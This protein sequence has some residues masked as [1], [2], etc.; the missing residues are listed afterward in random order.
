M[1]MSL[2]LPTTLPALESAPRS[3]DIPAGDA[4]AALKRF[5]AQAHEQ[6]L[7]STDD[8]SGLSTQ[9]IVG[10]FVPLAALHRML[11]NTPL[12]ARQDASTQ[13]ISITLSRPSR[14]P[15]AEP[16]PPAAAPLFPSPS[17]TPKP[18]STLKT[19]R[20]LT[21]FA[22]WLAA[23]SVISAQP[24]GSPGTISGRVDNLSTGRYLQGVEIRLDD[25][26]T[27]AVT[28]NQGRYSLYSVTGGDHTLEFSYVGLTTQKQAVTVPSGAN[29]IVDVSL[30]SNAYKLDK[31]VVV[32]ERE[33]RAAAISRQR[34]DP[35]IKGVIATDEYQNVSSGN[36]G[37]LLK[38]VPGVAIDYAGQDARS[39][40][41]RGIASNL[42]SVTVDSMRFASAASGGRG[43]SFDLDQVTLQNYS[44][45]EV[46]K[47]PTPDME[48]SSIGGNVNLVTKS[49]FEQKRRIVTAALNFNVTNYNLDGLDSKTRSINGG[50]TAEKIR[51]GGNLYFS[52]TFNVFGGR[53]NLGVVFTF[54]DFDT[55]IQA[56]RIN[57]DL[58][59]NTQQPNAD[60]GALNYTRISSWYLNDSPAQ[61][62]R[63]GVSLNLDYRLTA[64][65][66]L[67]LYTQ[68]NSSLIANRNRQFRLNANTYT[69]DSDLA[70]TTAV[71]A[72]NNQAIVNVDFN[73]KV[74]ASYGVNPG[75]KQMF[76]PLT[77]T[78]DVFVNQSANKYRDIPTYYSGITATLPN[79]GFTLNGRPDA[80]AP[81]VVQTAGPDLFNL[82]NY[83]TMQLNS[84]QRSGMDKF[85]GWKVDAKREFSGAIPFFLKTG[86]QSYDEYRYIDN[87]RRRWNYSGPA[88]NFGQLLDSTT[89]LGT[90]VTR[91]NLPQPPL[92][93]PQAVTAFAKANPQLFPEDKV[94]AIQSEAGR[95]YQHE[96]VTGAYFMGSFKFGQLTLLTGGRMEWT[97]DDGSGQRINRAAG[98]GIP[99]PIAQNL[100]VYAGRTRASNSYNNKFGN[101]QLKYEITRDLLVRVSGH[102]AIGRPDL[103]NILPSQNVD[104]PNRTVSINNVAIRP[105]VAGNID[106]SVE[107]YAP[108]A[109]TLTAGV[110][111]KN[112][113]DFITGLSTVIPAG[114]DNGF[115]GNYA[116]YTLNSQYNIG[117]A[118]FRGL[119]L[120][121]SQPFIGLPG[122]LSGFGG[123]AN[124]TWLRTEQDNPQVKGENFQNFVTRTVNVGLS[125]TRGR[126]LI[127]A[128]WNHRGTYWAYTSGGLNAYQAA[129]N[130]IDIAVRYP[131]Y[132]NIDFTFDAK[133][134]FNERTSFYALVP[135]RY[136]RQDPFGV[137]YNFGIRATF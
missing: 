47:A 25:G 91:W 115:Q 78:Y 101:V 117:F 79:I 72:A 135:G 55:I 128:K 60:I 75:A 43:R 88:G 19:S 51:P 73:D 57:K 35:G 30:D 95:S 27:E 6:L 102:Q 7:Y 114:P 36:I 71:Q 124:A 130:T 23:T 56:Y 8:V 111:R 76:G 49:A 69:A 86:A 14:A 121:A 80:S 116:G 21:F 66:T 98:I 4:T 65:T 13:A 5:A 53:S 89:K 68:A 61:T 113:R 119:E 134:L 1:G 64:S 122:W 106:A 109:T 133:N 46:S 120:G 131:L 94:Y 84:V 123:F 29:A 104:D 54:N 12:R 10:E 9:A 22:G 125:Y 85:V 17:P 83:S 105:Q 48:A 44:V 15:P 70:N 58:G 92:F 112:I 18:N 26:K 107:Y 82:N 127:S 99:D 59:R 40:R 50:G 108:T 20:I 126:M 52:D 38:N 96:R 110:F 67:H 24:T 118:R 62:H 3:F 2:L 93:S 74:G 28:D 45:I 42:N 11:A 37:E 81:A 129:W 16:L 136:I 41:V 33:G 132:R 87:P 34:S 32:G 137:S 97:S 103:G 31:F 39:I 90:T 100:A 63:K 77:L